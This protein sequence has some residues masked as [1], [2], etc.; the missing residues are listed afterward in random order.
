[1][2]LEPEE[3]VFIIYIITL[4]IQKIDV[5]LTIRAQIVFFFMKK[6]QA[7]ILNK[8]TDYADIFLPETAAKLSE[9]IGINNHPINLKTGKQLF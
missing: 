7:K 3:K 6:V 5:H 1:M 4:K 9:Q 2:A 8:Y